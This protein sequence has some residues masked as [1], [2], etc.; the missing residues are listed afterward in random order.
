MFSVMTQ[1][2]PKY[3]NP[4]KLIEAINKLPNPLIDKK[5]NLEI[6][7]EGYA[8]SNQTRVEHIVDYSHEL[9][10]RDI[11]LIEKGIK[12]YYFYKKDKTY[13]NTFNYYIK[14]RGLD[15]GFIKVSIR[16]DDYNPKKAWI[17]TIF[18]TYV[19]K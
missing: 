15:K 18:I 10:A 17:K 14:R 9:R 6:Y 12:D 2:R 1:R 7:I 8:R 19:V 3:Y 16:I 13:K 4:E 5:H 11:K